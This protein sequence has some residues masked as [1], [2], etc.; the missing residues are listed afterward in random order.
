MHMQGKITYPASAKPST[1]PL[2]MPVDPPVIKAE[3]PSNA[4]L[5]YCSSKFTRGPVFADTHG[6]CLD[7]FA[8]VF[9]QVMI[10]LTTK[11]CACGSTEFLVLGWVSEGDAAMQTTQTK[12]YTDQEAQCLWVG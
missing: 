11:V 9:V 8:I 4:D 7:M 10:V 5:S 12:R 2:P 1:H 6:I 3:R